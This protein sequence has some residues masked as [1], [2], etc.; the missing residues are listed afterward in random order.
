[1]VGKYQ[2]AE[3]DFT[4]DQPGLSLFHCHMQQHMDFGLM[5]L[6]DCD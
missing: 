6:F 2:E 5:C 4:A 1:M 3:V